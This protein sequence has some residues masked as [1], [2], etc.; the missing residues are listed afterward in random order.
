MLLPGSGFERP[1]S[2]P[3]QVKIHFLSNPFGSFIFLNFVLQN[4][5]LRV[6]FVGKAERE[7]E[8]SHLNS[9]RSS[10]RPLL[11]PP[12]I[13][14]PWTTARQMV[15]TEQRGESDRVVAGILLENMSK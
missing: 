12:S 15:D 6:D 11:R 5:V 7:R 4:S 3:K 14:D 9:T 8:R 2:S 13:L 10:L 1:S